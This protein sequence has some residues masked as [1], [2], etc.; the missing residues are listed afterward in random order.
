MNQD[1]ECSVKALLCFSQIGHL[2]VLRVKP[3]AHSETRSQA[4]ARMADHTACQQSAV[5]RQYGRPSY[6]I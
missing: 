3:V 2:Y 6:S 1:D 4:V 5:L